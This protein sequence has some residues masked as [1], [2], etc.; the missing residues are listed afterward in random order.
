MGRRGRS[1][2][3]ARPS[4]WCSESA[5]GPDRSFAGNQGRSRPIAFNCEVNPER[6][7]PRLGRVCLQNGASGRLRVDSSRFRCR[8]DRLVVGLVGVCIATVACAA[9][10]PFHSAATLVDTLS[11]GSI[12]VTNAPSGVWSPGTGSR[13]KIVESVRIGLVEGDGPQQFGEIRS[14][15][16]DDLDRMWLVDALANDLRVFEGDGTFV[17]AIGR[18]GEG[19]SEFQRIGDAFGGPGGRIWVEDLVR[20]RWE[21]FDTAGTRVEGHAVVSTVG[22]SPRAWTRQGLFAVLD[23]DVIEFYEHIGGRLRATDRSFPLPQ[24]RMPRMVSIE[25]GEGSVAMEVPPPFV[26]LPWM[27]L[28]SDLDL[29]L[30]DSSGEDGYYDIRRIGLD[31]GRAILTIRRRYSAIEIADSIRVAALESFRQQYTT[32]DMPPAGIGLGMVPREYPPFVDFQVSTD[33][34]LWVRRT[35]AGGVSGFDVFGPDGRYLGQPEMPV[36]L[37]AASMEVE[38]ITDQSIYAIDTDHLGV[39]Y[40]VRLDIVK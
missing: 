30:G 19:P 23:E 12:L 34:H 31:A 11:D 7:S 27:V 22:N 36:G 10:S 8:R 5:I 3:T 14:V 17:R 13:W 4:R 2:T 18:R 29:W 39:D 35:L 37:R 21:V 24:P 25:S 32:G 33:G 9:D 1:G 15:A 28:G 20:R 26:A 6:V 16:V 40:V 38:L